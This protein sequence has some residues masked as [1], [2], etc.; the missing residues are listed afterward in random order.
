MQ[1]LSLDWKNRWNKKFFFRRHS[2]EEIKHNELISKKHKK[3][4]KSLNYVELVTGCVSISAFAYVI[5]IP[6]GTTTSAVGLKLSVL[7]VGIKKYK[8][9]IK[10][11][12]QKHEY[13]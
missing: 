11:K 13:F 6:V 3:T 7:T 8:S 12:R 4:C 5:G 1:A 2:L 10:N 9:I